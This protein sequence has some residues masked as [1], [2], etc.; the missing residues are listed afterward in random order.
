MVENF[1]KLI[2]KKNP[3]HNSRRHLNYVHL[4]KQSKHKENHTYHA[5]IK[6]VKIKTRRKIQ[7]AVRKVIYLPS[8]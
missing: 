4:Y 8:D 1:P 2:K 7:K 5:V 3:S 6:L